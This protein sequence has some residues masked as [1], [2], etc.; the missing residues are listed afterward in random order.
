MLPITS[1]TTNAT[2]QSYRTDFELAK[3]LN[4]LTKHENIQNSGPTKI[5]LKVR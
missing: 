1:Q 3:K 4:K 5:F 2:S